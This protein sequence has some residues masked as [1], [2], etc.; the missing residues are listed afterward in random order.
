MT[1]TSWYI[2]FV[3]RQ[4]GTRLRHWHWPRTDAA[5]CTNAYPKRPGREE[6]H[7]V[8]VQRTETT[9]RPREPQ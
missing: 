7:R 5:N 6:T 1:R 2:C 9:Y 8:R 4:R 3:K